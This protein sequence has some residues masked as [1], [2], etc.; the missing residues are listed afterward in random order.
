MSNV[1]FNVSINDLSSN[2]LKKYTIIIFDIFYDLYEQILILFILNIFLIISLFSY[3]ILLQFIDFKDPMN[4]NIKPPEK[5]QL[6]EFI[7]MMTPQ[8]LS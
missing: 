3:V 1:F 2:L 5:V 4:M 8:L 7:V 6:I